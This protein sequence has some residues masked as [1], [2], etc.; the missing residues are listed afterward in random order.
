MNFRDGLHASDPRISTQG[1]P[2]PLQ[3]GYAR[4]VTT[5]HETS[6]AVLNTACCKYP[7]E[8]KA[9]GAQRS[10]PELAQKPYHLRPGNGAMVT[11]STIPP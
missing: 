11:F 8:E 2:L 6:C 3:I 9:F 10:R 7:F 1:K 4:V 5:R